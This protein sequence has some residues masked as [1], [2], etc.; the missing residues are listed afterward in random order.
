VGNPFSTKT[1]GGFTGLTL[2]TAEPYF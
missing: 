1:S 2:E